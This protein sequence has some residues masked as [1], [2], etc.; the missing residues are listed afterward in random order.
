MAAWSCLLLTAVAAREASAD[1]II[2]RSGGEIR[3]E[4][5]SDPNQ[6]PSRPSGIKSK[7]AG[8]AEKGGPAERGEIVS[9]RTLS[10]ATVAVGQRE[11]ES[12]VRRK[13][14]LEEYES[15]R[16]AAPNTVEAQWDL[17]EW[18]R[19]K[20]LPKERESHLR[21]VVAL[22]PD[23]VA[24][25]RGL[26]H[27]KDR[28]GQWAT[29]DE[30]M[31][32]RGYV[33]HKGKYI[34]PQELEL[35]QQDERTSEAEKAWFKK[36]R[37]WHLWL[38][39][40]RADR[41][42]EA[43]TQLRAV[44]DPDA[45]PALSKYFTAAPNEDQRMLYVEILTR[46]FGDKP[47]TQLVQQSLWDESQAIRKAAVAGVRQKDASKALP[48]YLRALKSGYNIIVNR[49]GDALGQ[50]GNDTV[51]PQMI[52][53]LVTRHVYTELVPDGGI[54]ATTGGGMVPG[55]PVLPANIDLLLAA[56]QLPQGVR[57]EYPGAPVRMKEITYE[58]DERNASVLEALNALTGQDFGYDE[59]AWRK[60]FN[61]Q[62]N[63][64]GAKKK[65][66]KP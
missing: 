16:R 29:H 49:A 27:M 47:V 57:V 7:T 15:L 59:V 18:C 58:K 48:F 66:L 1:Y 52:Q 36:V 30:V 9:I 54:G 39:G 43:L 28:Q 55:Q 21:T 35:L 33:K 12:I 65:K 40:D 22:D 20:S 4:L 8:A 45:V 60:W 3:G 6:R 13:M 41:Q 25:H 44:Q 53:A 24:A 32:S 51:V 64:P 23:H 37:T 50:L 38:E 56:G 2:L 31:L 62:H 34:L 19:Q 42:A 63:S 11:V 10:G 5:L 14:I 46:I 26:G 61:A 17:A